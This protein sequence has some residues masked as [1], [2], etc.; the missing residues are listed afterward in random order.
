MSALK[1]VCGFVILFWWLIGCAYGKPI[2]GLAFG[3]F[4]CCAVILMLG[5]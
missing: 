1:A 2:E 5:A 3:A 4:T